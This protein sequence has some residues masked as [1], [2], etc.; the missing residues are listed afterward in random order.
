MPSKVISVIFAFIF[1]TNFQI[2]SAAKA[3][4]ETFNFCRL[5]VCYFSFK[6]WIFTNNSR[7]DLKNTQF[8]TN[9]ILPLTEINNSRPTCKVS[10]CLVLVFFILTLFFKF[11]SSFF[12]Q[13][14][15]IYSNEEPQKR[16]E[17][18]KLW[19]DC[20]WSSFLPADIDRSQLS[21]RPP[22]KK[23]IIIKAQVC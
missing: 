19:R 8:E 2:F 6:P 10:S 7:T 23:L 14:F 22:P 21:S 1:I 12:G 17:Q 3:K 5:S 4:I 11:C 20:S 13:S 15:I 16:Y 9:S 18:G